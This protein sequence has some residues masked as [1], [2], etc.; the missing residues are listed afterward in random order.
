MF[1]TWD[2]DWFIQW[3]VL[4]RCM[5]LACQIVKLY[6]H[7]FHNLIISPRC[8]HSSWQQHDHSKAY[9][10]MMDTDS[11]GG[12]TSESCCRIRSILRGRDAFPFLFVPSTGSVTSQG[13][14][15][16]LWFSIWDTC[17]YLCKNRKLL[18]KY[19]MWKYVISYT[20]VQMPYI[21]I[22]F[23]FT[24]KHF[25]PL[26]GKLYS[27]VLFTYLPF[28]SDFFACPTSRKNKLSSVFSDSRPL[29]NIKITIYYIRNYT[30]WYLVFYA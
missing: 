7:R 19:L 8:S 14:H 24:A 13:K 4:L 2:N 5:H 23:V 16:I 9:G 25:L 6:Y 29:K 30:F 26:G 3:W 28:C 15:K 12:G 17:L 21:Y 11:L 18:P 10:A 27:V 20:R 22:Y 1:S